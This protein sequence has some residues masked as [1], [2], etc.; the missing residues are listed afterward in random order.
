MVIMMYSLL[1]PLISGDF[2]HLVQK[3][4]GEYIA[5][6]GGA[7]DDKGQMFIHVKAI[8]YMIKNKGACRVNIKC[9]FEGEEE[10]GSLDLPSF[11]EPKYKRCLN[12]M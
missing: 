4:T 10:I 3:L 12:A 6:Q 8:E 2:P 9:L 11:M 1:N 5:M 7:S